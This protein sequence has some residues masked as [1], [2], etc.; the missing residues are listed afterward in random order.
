MLSHSVELAKL[1]CEHSKVPAS[2]QMKALKGWRIN[3]RDRM[4]KVCT[5]IVCTIP[6]TMAHL[7][8]D[9]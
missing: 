5:N 1:F 3:Q 9:Y 8:Q 4:Q 7:P 6:V 2:L